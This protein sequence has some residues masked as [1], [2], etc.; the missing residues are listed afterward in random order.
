M[1][2]GKVKKTVLCERVV[3][4]AITRARENRESLHL[5]MTYTSTDFVAY[6]FSLD[7]VAHSSRCVSTADGRDFY[8]P[9]AAN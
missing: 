1:L 8:L 5:Y 9:S 3:V 7:V 4:L 2:A 6:V